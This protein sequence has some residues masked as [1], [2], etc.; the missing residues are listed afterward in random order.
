MR[1]DLGFS[2][3][4]KRED[5][6]FNSTFMN[7]FKTVWLGFEAFNLLDIRNTINY[8]WIRIIPNSTN[9]DL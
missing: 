4:L 7:S 9:P 8:S 1:A 3:L 6:K 2:L 5:K